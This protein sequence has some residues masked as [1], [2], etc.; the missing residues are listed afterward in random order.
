MLFKTMVY[1]GTGYLQGGICTGRSIAT[2][3]SLLTCIADGLC[4]DIANYEDGA[5]LI[6]PVLLQSP[7]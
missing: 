2:I 3:T 1:Y 6:R 4:L 7:E 5:D